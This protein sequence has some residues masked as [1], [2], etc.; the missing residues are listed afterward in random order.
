MISTTYNNLSLMPQHLPDK[1]FSIPHYDMIFSYLDEERILPSGWG[2]CRR[3]IAFQIDFHI[4]YSSDLCN[5]FLIAYPCNKDIN[6]GTFALSTVGIFPK[7]EHDPINISIYFIQDIR[8]V[9]VL[10]Q[11]TDFFKMFGKKYWMAISPFLNTEDP[12]LT[13]LG[14]Y[15][16]LFFFKSWADT[17]AALT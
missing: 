13:P 10:F 2:K 14:G 15:Q 5:L 4:I 17:V 9:G 8:N 16:Y 12:C 7:Q 3:R 6:I 11:E 1:C